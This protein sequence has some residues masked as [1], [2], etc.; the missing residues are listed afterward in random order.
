MAKI[1]LNVTV[2]DQT[3]QAVN[4]I[5]SRFDSISS[6]YG[7]GTGKGNASNQNAYTEAVKKTNKEIAKST[8]L[9]KENAGSYKNYQKA[10][11]S[12]T[13]ATKNY[14][15]SV[16]SATDANIKQQQSLSSMMVGF[17][18][19]QLVAT[20][21]M[22]PIQ[23][24]REGYASLN[25]TLVETENTVISLQRV[26]KEDLSN[27]Q[28]SGELYRIAQQYGQTF[29]N[30]SELAT[31]FA[32]TG[33]A[34]AD[35][36]KAVEAAVI[37]LNVAELDASQ[38]SDGM[39]AILTQFGK[40]AK[41]LEGIVDMLN[42]TADNYAVTTGKI[43]AALQR[44]GSSAS[45]ANIS[46]EHT[47]GLITA[48]SEATGR[49]GENIGTA[50]NSLIQYSSKD[51]ALK[52]FSAL[53]PNMA[54]IVAEYKKGAAS[55]LD[56]WKG[57]SS[58]IKSLTDEQAD[59][60]DQYFT[61][62]E[63]EALKSELD[64]ELGDIYNDLSGVYST[65]NTFRKNYFI[66]L[67]NNMDT[68]LKATETASDAAGYSQ[69]ENL[70]YMET[71]TAK[72]NE[73]KGKWEEVANAEQ[74]WLEFK[75][76]LAEAGIYALNLVEN[77]GGLKTLFSA[78][79][80]ATG[81]P[82]LTKF[83]G[84]LSKINVTSLASHT[85][86][87][88]LARVFT[89]LRKAKQADIAVTQAQNNLLLAQRGIT[90][91]NMSVEE[92]EIA[93]TKAK[94]NADI[95]GAAAAQARNAALTMG[96]SVM[97]SLI[98][99]LVSWLGKEGEQLEKVNQELSE[100]ESKL[101]TV[102][103]ELETTKQRIAE[104]EGK[105]TLTFVEQEELNR[106]RQENSELERTN[107]LLKEQQRIKQRERNK[108]FVESSEKDLKDNTENVPLII[109]ALSPGSATAK[110]EY[111][112]IEQQFSELERLRKE[113]REA[114]TEEEKKA[115]QKQ[116]DDIEKYLG[117]KSSEFLERMEGIEYIPEP[118]TEDEKKVNETLDFYNNFFDRMMIATGAEGAKANA[119]AR[120]VDN[121]KFDKLLDP[122]QKLGKEGKVTAEMLKNPAY[123]EF[124][125]T[126]KNIGFI[127]NTT[128]AS[129][130]R[131]ANAFNNVGAEAKVA[132]LNTD[133]AVNS[134]IANLEDEAKAAE[135]T[136]EEMSDLVAQHILFG[137][138]NLS[139]DQKLQAL[140][141]LDKA[142]N[143]TNTRLATLVALTN[144]LSDPNAGAN[145]PAWQRE[146]Y[147]TFAKGKRD[148]I[149]AEWKKEY[150]A[151]KAILDEIGGDDST[152]GDTPSGTKKE[153]DEILEALQDSISYEEKKLTLMQHQGA[154]LE[155]QI[156]QIEKI[157]GLEHDIA[158]YLRSQGKS[159][160]ETLEYQNKWWTLEKNKRDLILN[161]YKD[162]ISL[163][164][165][166]ISLMEHQGKSE[167]EI[168]ALK[169]KQQEILHEQAEYLRSIGAE[170]EEINK[171]SSEWWTVEED[172]NDTLKE[173]LESARDYQN[174]L[175][176][177]EIDALEKARDVE[178][179]QLDIEEKKLAVLEAQQ[180]LLDAR[181][182]R[183]V[184]VYNAK[185][186]MWE[187]IADPNAI[188]SAQDNLSSAEKDLDDARFEQKISRLEK[189]KEKN[190]ARY[191]GII[192][193]TASFTESINAMKANSSA[194]WTASESEK[195]MLSDANL[196][197]GTK[198]GLSRGEDGS[199]YSS[200]GT[201]V[202]DDGGILSGLGG[203]KATNR[204]EAVLDPELTSKILS[205]TSNKQFSDFASSVGLLFGTS[206][207]LA[208]GKTVP[209]FQ[210]GGATYHDRHDVNINGIPITSE[211]ASRYTVS[212]L[213]DLLGLV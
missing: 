107:T 1:T 193:G 204:P 51:S 114:S 57:L 48:L 89:T 87:G 134:F 61:T 126:L 18:K 121:W 183:N 165:S 200:N 44:T 47:I 207:S 152:V 5:K 124:L 131:V 25:E 58:E 129:L 49:S 101:D 170:Q 50:L 62:A 9:V 106:L 194:W 202:Y 90:S 4:S 203:I 8:R 69:K 173:I 196:A 179:E 171:L 189:E 168:I 208:T 156:A 42:K 199:W 138:T 172:I 6:G 154:S 122:L 39:I 108:E 166:Q 81:L 85:A 26:L 140:A 139:V 192:D 117:D 187:W 66:A 120:I 197:I 180:A 10:A 23:L 76:D 67:L 167:F 137:N 184:R 84:I 163:L 110:T 41:D 7:G 45:N 153:T 24:I 198:L 103:A 150:E 21:V 11:D 68:V 123:K 176:Q 63:G 159:E 142:I 206:R 40:E 74:G 55:I 111:E 92:A 113:K 29:E 75:K 43:L 164:G 148:S 16:K 82:V 35:V 94:T 135:I 28:I 15:K 83:V 161:S 112:Y 88:K 93:L 109:R 145:L 32:R 20:L 54:G 60:L 52:T 181:N 186:G 149:I 178:K 146:Q 182:Q 158:E 17:A 119:F 91:V 136:T 212:E 64:A 34:Y 211:Q 132:T 130:I 97:I 14:E 169:R 177:K 73:L 191:N 80:Y 79:L 77:L 195:K 31:N 190:D 13:K 70:Q 125:E 104:L 100:I 56:V 27:D 147:L 98:P 160:E 141:N 38:A 144:V 175:I 102:N 188:K 157:Q 205:P 22:K 133:E 2:N 71:Y 162:E 36:I 46:L 78:L 53:S 155:D 143:G 95:A 86:I 209:S 151:T 105:G 72:V 37:A 3:A 128:D 210:N 185:S 174:D 116:I 19:W 201:K 115:I 33:M 118:T 65:A 30:V 127:S 59:L 99:L 12:A 213:F 96:L